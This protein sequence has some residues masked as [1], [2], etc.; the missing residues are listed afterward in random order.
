MEKI[1]YRIAKTITYLFHPI[2]LPLY[3][4][5]LLFNLKSFFSFGIVLNARLML[6]GFVVITTIIFPLIIVFLMKRQGL[7]QSYLM[8]T[9]QERRYPYL[10]IAVF[11]FL[12]YNIFRQLQLPDIYTF[13]MMGATF[14]VIVVIIINIWWKISIHMV[15]IGGV[16]GIVAGLSLNMSL[17]LMFPIMVIILIAGLVGY[18]RLKLNSHK[19]SEIYTGFFV[20]AIIMLG[21]F[22]FL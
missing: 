14:L 21:I 9:R 19:P 20:G 16:F 2:F 5:L 11:Y 13:Y 15:G 3:C 7:I 4:L 10:I 6:I 22:C 8:E 12:T 18:A 1:E 17:D